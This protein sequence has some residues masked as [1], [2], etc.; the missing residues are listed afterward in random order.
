MHLRAVLGRSSSVRG[1]CELVAAV[2]LARPLREPAGRVCPWKP[3]AAVARLGAPLCRATAAEPYRYRSPQ[4][5]AALVFSAPGRALPARAPS[6]AHVEE[7]G[8]VARTHIGREIRLTEGGIG[9]GGSTV[10][11]PVEWILSTIFSFCHTFW[12][13]LLKALC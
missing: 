4:G 9:I 12:I 1:E 3:L 5:R 2:A 7:M 6:A 8:G 11:A 10:S 13:V